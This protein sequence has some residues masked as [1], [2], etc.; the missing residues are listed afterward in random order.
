[1]FEEGNRP[2]LD[3]LALGLA[4]LFSVQALLNYAQTYW[5]SATG[6]R[7][8]AGLRTELFAKLLE[9][10]PGFFAERR[11]GE[12]TSRL[13]ADIGLLQGILSH[14][15]ADFSR[16]V[17]ALVGGV[18]VL[19]LMQP[20]LM[21]TALAVVPIVVGSAMIFGKRLKRI[22]TGVQD[23]L[24]EST[25]LADEAFSQIRVVQGFAQEPH[26]R[27]RYGERIA[28]LIGAAL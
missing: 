25:A 28:R 4:A 19:T 26:E 14:Q 2:L 18:T 5:L 13:T 21:L 9:M 10:P 24:A 6:E 16:Q 27:Q 15:L 7:A 12:L 17:L 20:R 11:T 22:T 23:E 1:A 3:R 8:V